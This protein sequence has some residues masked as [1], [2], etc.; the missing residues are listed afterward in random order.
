MWENEKLSIF[1]SAHI[2]IILL[3]IE[4]DK[5]G[6]NYTIIV[7]LLTVWADNNDVTKIYINRNI[8]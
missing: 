5:N 6:N 1:Y 7:T 4:N 3:Y 2:E 8:W